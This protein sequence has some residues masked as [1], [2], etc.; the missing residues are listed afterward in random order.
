VDYAMIARG[1][2]IPSVRIEQ[3]GDLRAGLAAA[4]AADG[5]Y[6]VDVVTDP[7]ALSMPPHVSAQQI[8]GFAMAAGKTVLGGGVGKM[9]ELARSNLRNARAL[10]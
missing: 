1:V 8:R 5:P 4:L 7:N 10:G 3:P 9:V 2:G 6:L